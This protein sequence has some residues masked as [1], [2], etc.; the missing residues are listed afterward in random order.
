MRSG[1]LGVSGFRPPVRGST[2]VSLSGSSP[3]LATVA[4]ARHLQWLRGQVVQAP[5]EAEAVGAWC[6]QVRETRVSYH[7]VYGDVHIHEHERKLH[8]I[9]PLLVHVFVSSSTHPHQLCRLATMTHDLSSA[10]P[11][12]IWSLSTGSRDHVQYNWTR[13]NQTVS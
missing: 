7:I 3:E 2:S 1:V 11:S 6:H 13:H 5:P 4:F 10:P 9:P 8:Y 12:H